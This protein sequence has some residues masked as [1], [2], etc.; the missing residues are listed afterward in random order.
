[1]KVAYV[2][3]H[4]SAHEAVKVLESKIQ[5]IR[6]TDMPECVRLIKKF[7]EEEWPTGEPAGEF[8]R[9]VLEVA[10]RKKE[11][12]DMYR[13]DHKYICDKLLTQVR[14]RQRY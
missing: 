5:D 1:V 10:A 12:D 2:M 11:D 3:V 4:A 7:W 13:R 8:W 6:Y 9:D 14:G